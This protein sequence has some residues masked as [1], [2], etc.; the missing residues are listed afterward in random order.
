MKVVFYVF[1][2]VLGAAFGSFLCCQAWRLRLTEK[3]KGK[4]SG[5]G[6]RS[7]C[8]E[9]K[10]TLKW[11]D[12]IP[13]V[14][15]LVLRGKCRYCKKKI[16][17]SEIIA[18]VL[19]GVVFLILARVFLVDFGG[20][21]LFN[22]ALFATS[23]SASIQDILLYTSFF[24]LILLSLVLV[25]LAIY[26]GKWGELPTVF[27]IIDCVLAAAFWGLKGFAAGFSVE[28]FWH[29][30]GALAI[31][32]GLYQLLYLISKGRWVGDGDAILCIAL[33]LV[34]GNAWLAIFLLFIANTLGCLYGL[35]GMIK[36]KKNL[37]I[38]F[39]P[40]LVAALFIILLL[41]DYLLGLIVF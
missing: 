23:H 29:T 8:L 4:K 12:N 17:A 28:Y 11:Y 1:A 2:F 32:A 19:T 26:D 9:C 38:Y 13:I 27:L 6:K 10:K 16:G 20:E 18:E 30:L 24:V 34:I 14:S 37:K 7:V 3:G 31:L 40:F 15:W 35:P 22:N 33:A 41:K 39:G 25:F 36:G 21:L 5:L